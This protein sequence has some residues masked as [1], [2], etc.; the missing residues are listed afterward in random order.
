MKKTEKIGSLSVL[1]DEITAMVDEGKI[2]ALQIAYEAG[3]SQ[4]TVYAFLANKNLN[5]KIIDW[6]LGKGGKLW[7]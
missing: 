4:P 5:V 2:T 7:R 1:R 6:Y 3:V